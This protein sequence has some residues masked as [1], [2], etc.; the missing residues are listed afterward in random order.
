MNKYSRNIRVQELN[1]TKRRK[2]LETFKFTS[3]YEFTKFQKIMKYY[4][5]SLK[6]GTWL[7]TNSVNFKNI[8]N[9]V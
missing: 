5:S 9:E 3:F 2:N 1:V 6:T 8:Q 7:S 4:F